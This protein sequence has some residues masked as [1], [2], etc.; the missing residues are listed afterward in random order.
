VTRPV[1]IGLD[2]ATL[3]A[4]DALAERHGTSRSGVVRLLVERATDPERGDP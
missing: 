1:T 2:G 3:D 4:L